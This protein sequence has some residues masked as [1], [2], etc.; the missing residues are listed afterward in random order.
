MFLNV[1]L[2]QK[3]QE[4]DVYKIS[5]TPDASAESKVYVPADL[6]DS[7]RELKK[8]LHPELIDK[9]RQNPEE[10]M[11]VH[12]MG[13]G[14]WMRNNWGLWRGS[15]LKSYFNGIGVF[16]PDDMS[17]IILNSFWR[18]LNS[19]PLNLDEQIAYYRLFWKVNAEPEKKRCPHD[20][21][22]IE[23]TVQ[24]DESEKNQPRTIHAG[25]CG[26]KKHFWA[27]EH[28]K[29]WYQPDAGLLRKI[30]LALSEAEAMATR[31][32]VRQAVG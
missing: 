6:A 2:A 1:C 11:I 8:M 16:H 3:P 15:R 14:L 26:K 10:E 32:P 21:S 28:D 18:H 5:P 12:H 9:M 25:R 17:G 31:E 27:Y 7:F 23:I 29:G 30:K 19:K 20:G 4:D 24:F 13:L 22:I